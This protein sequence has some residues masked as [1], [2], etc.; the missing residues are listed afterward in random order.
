M[1]TWKTTKAWAIGTCSRIYQVNYLLLHASMEEKNSFILL[2]SSQ[3][4]SRTAAM[5]TS[6]MIIITAIWCT[7]WL[8][9][10]AD[11]VMFLPSFQEHICFCR[12]VLTEI[13]CAGGYWIDALPRSQLLQVLHIMV[14]NSTEWVWQKNKCFLMD[15]VSSSFWSVCALDR[16][17]IRRD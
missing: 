16:R 5:E 3:D 8:V 4:A 2:F 12:D 11:L 9:L 1:P 14:Q 6:R 10:S 13:S 7:F 15:V 17:Q